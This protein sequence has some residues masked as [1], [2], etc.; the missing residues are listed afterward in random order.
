MDK[1]SPAKESHPPSRVNV[2]VPLY[3]K[4]LALYTTTTTTITVLLLLLLIVI[5]I[6]IIIT[7]LISSKRLFSFDLQCQ[8]SKT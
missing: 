1:S 7:L 4:R 2:S 6:V 5:I 8:I 3:E